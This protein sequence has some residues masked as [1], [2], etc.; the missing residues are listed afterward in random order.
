[1][2]SGR[3][4]QDASYIPP[5]L[6]TV[7]VVSATA[8]ATVEITIDP[9][10]R[11]SFVTLQA[12][13]ADVFYALGV[14]GGVVDSSAAGAPAATGCARLPAGATRSQWITADPAVTRL[15]VRGRT[16]GAD[17][18]LRAWKSSPNG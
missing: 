12:E 11:G 3:E 17:G 10:W 18:L 9:A 4:W 5:I 13:T 6:G 7:Y 14:T 8:A 1:M 16:A 2:S 15:L